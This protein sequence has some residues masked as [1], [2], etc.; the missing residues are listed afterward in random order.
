MVK[1]IDCL[2]YHLQA[3]AYAVFASFSIAYCVDG[4]SCMQYQVGTKMTDL[5]AM[6]LSNSHSATVFK[7]HF[8]ALHNRRRY[9]QS[10]V[11]KQ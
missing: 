6:I 10:P 11:R 1:T 3:A 2:K 8:I 9:R 5:Y 7:L 4:E